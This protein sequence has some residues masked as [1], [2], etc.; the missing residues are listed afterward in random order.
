MVPVFA[1]TCPWTGVPWMSKPSIHTHDPSVP[2]ARSC[3]ISIDSVWT[4][5]GRLLAP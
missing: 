3:V 4:P 2:A 1:V 5:G